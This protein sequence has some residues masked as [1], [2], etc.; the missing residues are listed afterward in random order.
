MK[1]KLEILTGSSRKPLLSREVVFS[2]LLV[3]KQ[4]EGAVDRTPGL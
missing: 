1:E 3:R 2:E 4:P